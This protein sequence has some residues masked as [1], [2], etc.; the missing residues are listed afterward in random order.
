MCVCVSLALF[1]VCAL[2]RIKQMDKFSAALDV[3][4]YRE[5]NINGALIVR[6]F[7]S[8]TSA[9]LY[10]SVSFFFFSS[11]SVRAG[12]ALLWNLLQLPAIFGTYTHSRILK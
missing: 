8:R 4:L 3:K 9:N 11:L 12:L 1:V 10:L 2:E 5:Y 6:R 7:D